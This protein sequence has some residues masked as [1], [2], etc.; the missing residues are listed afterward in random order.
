MNRV[1]KCHIGQGSSEQ[2]VQNGPG[3]FFQPKL[4]V[5]QPNDAY[6]QEADA[7]AD[8]VM[9]MEQPFVQA[10]PLPVSGI[11][12]KCAHC[13]EEEKKAQRKEMNG[14]EVGVDDFFESYV[15]GLNGAGQTLPNEVRS[16]YEP[17]F[18]YDF[19]NVKIHSD[20]VAAKSAQS[21][22]ALAYTSGNNIV[23]NEGQYSP[24]TD[25]GKRLL[26]HELT[27][28]IQQNAVSTIQRQ[29]I[30]DDELPPFDPR[31]PN[32]EGPL[33]DPFPEMAGNPLTFDAQDATHM[34]FD[35]DCPRRANLG[36]V[37]PS[38]E[39]EVGEEDFDGRVFTF[40]ENSDILSPNDQLSDMITFARQQPAFSTFNVAGYASKEGNAVQNFN[41]SCH[42]AKRTARIL[43]NAGVRSE[44]L[45][46]VNRGVTERFGTGNR[47]QA[48]RKNRV[49]VIQVE[50]T[51]PQSAP[52][53]LPSNR[54]DIVDLA[55]NRIL[56]GEY[57]LGADAYLSFWTCGHV[58]S[59]ARA[60]ERTTIMIEGEPN[61]PA[62]GRKL[63]QDAIGN[64]KVE[65]LNTII[66]PNEMFDDTFNTLECITA[67]IIDLAVHHA[68]RSNIPL[69]GDA[70][71]AGMYIVHLAGFG[72]CLTTNP[73]IV[74]GQITRVA[75]APFASTIPPS[76]D[77]RQDMPHPCNGQALP[78]P[79]GTASAAGIHPVP[80]FIV[81][82]F[83]LNSDVKPA[84]I[85]ADDEAVHISTPRKFLSGKAKVRAAGNTADIAN[86]Q[87]GFIQT[88]VEQ[89]ETEDYVS[90]HQLSID[91]PVPLLDGPQRSLGSPRPWFHPATV[92]PA[93]SNDTEF[94][95]LDAPNSFAPRFNIDVPHSVLESM[96]ISEDATS[97][98]RARRVSQNN[99]PINR[100]AF[101][102]VFHTWVVARRNDAP[103]DRFSTHF[104]QGG[105][106]TLDVNADFT[107]GKGSGIANLQSSASADN[108]QMQLQ[109]PVPNDIIRPAV[110]LNFS[111]PADRAQAGG[112]SLPDYVTEV[113]RIAGPIRLKHGITGTLTINIKIDQ[114]T[115]RIRL[116][117]AGSTAPVTIV[118]QS[119]TAASREACRIELL[120]NLRKDMV[121]APLT[122]RNANLETVPVTM[123]A[124]SSQS[125]P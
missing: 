56:R 88:L 46:V 121:L 117:R 11:Q 15:G 49:V 124:V 76:V 79:L 105:I 99:N 83:D 111:N 107:G 91:L 9:R 104:L 55:R 28:T 73:T 18:G 100:A 19:S 60:V 65:G 98:V 43:M 16:F 80:N 125:N 34:S 110:K 37:E 35:A 102:Y 42:R 23:F 92:H 70:H 90:G 118:T 7:M 112:R 93:S 17:R 13:E 89:S 14:D 3:N 82:D 2:V 48:L 63:G 1:H 20:S 32:P 77:P 21:I 59:L 10:K 26:G 53:A 103:L 114:Q 47:E 40:C 30:P 75:G 123:P 78:G 69:H 68:V 66:L 29:S 87:V 50:S 116:E 106:W 22:N 51:P 95:I 8:K 108:S 27:H 94:I 86:Y 38:P 58:P 119:G 67:R 85:N 39:C 115:G 72:A 4:T 84:L 24:G 12:R 6:E 64:P 52:T 113:R 101:H 81:T 62:V 96:N 109:D 61:T 36:A 45:H 120:E 97:R 44:R 41:L 31:Q 5:N 74:N 54:R 25:S 122:G 71:D 57:N 33:E